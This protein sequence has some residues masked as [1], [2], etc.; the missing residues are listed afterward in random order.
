MKPKFLQNSLRN[1]IWAGPTKK[2]AR[3]FW[4]IAI[5]FKLAKPY[6]TFAAE[7]MVFGILRPTFKCHYP[8]IPIKMCLACLFLNSIRIFPVCYRHYQF[9]ATSKYLIYLN[10][11]ILGIYLCTLQMIP[12]RIT[13]SLGVTIL[14]LPFSFTHSKPQGLFLPKGFLLTLLIKTI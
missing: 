7:Q 10:I 2:R 11:C 3:F 6:Q 14:K 9:V 12:E 5:R 1:R 13:S 4:A 8:D